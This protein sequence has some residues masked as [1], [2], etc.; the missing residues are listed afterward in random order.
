ML[1]VTDRRNSRSAQRELASGLALILLI[2]LL[3]TMEG[4]PLGQ[5]TVLSDEEGYLE[6]RV[7]QLHRAME[8]EDFATWHRL[9]SS[10]AV[11]GQY[12]SLEEFKRNF[13]DPYG[14]MRGWGVREANVKQICN[15]A[16]YE[17]SDGPEVLRCALLVH[18]VFRN[19]DAA[20]ELELW[21]HLNSGWYLSHTEARGS[22]RAPR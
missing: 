14:R 2:C 13:E 20:D 10:S 21:D 18:F 1:G 22:C 5:G 11:A 16:D 8:S 6:S 15:C 17:Y 7:A 4:M 9:S 19:G 3:L 12:L